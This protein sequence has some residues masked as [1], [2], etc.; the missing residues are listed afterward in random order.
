MPS[1]T[2]RWRRWFRGCRTS[3]P[4]TYR[5]RCASFHAPRFSA[6]A[7]AASHTPRTSLLCAAQ[8]D[9]RVP[10][11][12]VVDYSAWDIRIR[13]VTVLPAGVAVV[14]V[15]G[16]GLRVLLTGGRV[17]GT[18]RWRAKLLLAFICCSCIRSFLHSLEWATCSCACNEWLHFLSQT[19][20]GPLPRLQEVQVARALR[21]LR[22]GHR[23]SDGERGV[24]GA[25]GR[26]AK[27]RRGAAGGEHRGPQRRVWALHGGAERPV[28]LAVQRVFGVILLAHLICV[29][30]L[31]PACV[32][33]LNGVAPRTLQAIF[34]DRVKN[35]VE[36]ALGDAV[37]REVATEGNAALATLPV[38]QP[39]LNA[40]SLLDYSL[41]GQP[42]FQRGQ[43]RRVP[44]I[45]SLSSAHVFLYRGRRG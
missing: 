18:L 4:P 29:H 43:V 41:V 1:K 38:T 28:R 42:T 40:S 23:R 37:V 24:G 26:R 19:S 8:V 21:A 17:L 36:A 6:R 35:T 12:R 13:N 27:R 32:T 5:A 34:Y 44:S 9:T 15:E 39:F 10:L 2:R 31:R 25:A 14:P 3:T 16:Q 30:A 33:Y 20:A 7:D 11:V 45:R 22:R